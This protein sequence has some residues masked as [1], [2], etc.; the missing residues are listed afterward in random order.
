MKVTPDEIE[1]YDYYTIALNKNDENIILLSFYNDDSD[2]GKL[3][4]E[5][6]LNS[7]EVLAKDLLAL[8]ELQKAKQMEQV[9]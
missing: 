5:F 9:Q 4:I 7:A 8:I 2:E 3:H 6:T 1:D